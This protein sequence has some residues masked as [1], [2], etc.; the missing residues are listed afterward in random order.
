MTGSNGRRA[1]V[2]LALF[3]AAC[4]SQ[5]VGG[6][7]DFATPPQQQPDAAQAPDLAPTGCER[8]G[9]CAM[10]GRR[11]ACCAGRCLDVSGD[12]KNCGRCG[13]ACA[14][15][16]CDGACSDPQTD[17]RN[18]GGCGMACSTTHA[19]SACAG[20]ECGLGAC[21]AGWGDCDHDA[22][23]GCE[24]NLHV[25]AANC[26]ACGMACA[27]PHGVTACAD[28]CYLAACEFG[29]DDCNGDPSDGCEQSVLDDANNCGGCGV[30]CAAVP[31][32]QASCVNATCE[33]TSCNQGFLD[34]DHDANNGCEVQGATDAKN[35][36]AC[37]VACAPGQVCKG[38]GCTCPMCNFPNASASCVNNQCVFEQCNPGYTN[39]DQN[40]QNGCEVFT[41]GDPKNCGG[42]GNVCPQN[43]PGCLKGQC[44]AS[45][46]LGNPQWTRVTC[47]ITSWVWSSDNT[48]KTLVDANAAHTLQTGCHHATDAA[49]QQQNNWMC[50]LDG[51]GWVSTQTFVMAGCNQSWWHVGGSFS[52]QCGGHDGDVTRHLVLGDND[53][54]PY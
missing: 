34:C 25:D 10:G 32:G 27:L 40:T 8:D 24:T 41:D 49:L 30:R 37:G 39:C 42:C 16:C 52:G 4:G 17:A 33:L 13:N 31:N 46:C 23:N 6:G 47:T 21:E 53:C 12:A 9:D 2:S 22:K 19:T 54:Y 35:C 50:S 3:L 36:G 44:V 1:V 45:P 15:N 38:G 43:L 11:M 51:K 26:T 29:F 5:P 18:C 7:G 48:K 28:G 20:G 14:G